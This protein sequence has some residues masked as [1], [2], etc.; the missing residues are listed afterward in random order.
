MTGDKKGQTDI[1]IDNLPG[2]PDN[3]RFNAAGELWIAQPQ[4]RDAMVDYTMKTTFLRNL[5]G[6]LPLSILLLISRIGTWTGGVKVNEKGEVLEF[7]R[8]PC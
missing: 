2:V 5:F 1:L 3:L 6:K 7:F 8:V 4:M